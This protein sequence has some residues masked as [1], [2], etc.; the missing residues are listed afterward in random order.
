MRDEGVLG[1]VGVWGHLDRLDGD[2]LQR[3]AAGVE[4]LGYGTL[5]VPETVGREPFVALAA[6]ALSSTRLRVGTS[7]ASIWARD[8][9]SMKM[10][11]RTLQELSG[12]RFRLG[13][14]VS[15]HH[16]AQKVRG[17]TYERPLTRMREYLE[18]Y[19]A[20]PYRGP[21][22]DPDADP[23]MLLAALRVR[24]LELAA[25]ETDGV[26]PYLVT[27]ERVRWMRGVIDAVSP[28]EDQRA[29]LAVTLPVVVTTDADEGRAIAR[30]Y[31]APY[32][33]TPN[34]H[35]SWLAQG[36][37][38]SDWEKPGSDRLVEEM[39][40][41]GDVGTL[42]Q[43]VRE[44]HAAGAD[45]VALIPLGLDGDTENMATLEVLADELRDS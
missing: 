31:L 21:V 20:A 7:I 16:L 14:G 33:R 36:F 24:M 12:G 11:A 5:W 19:R 26:F 8:A 41:T 15:H 29:L 1:S 40:A 2:A 23:P 28:A 9:V 35:A 39:V 25:T 45:H 43:R 10:A 4:E 32:L 34:Y 6:A 22:H 42:V 17:H 13:L 38:E 27:S 30:A 37:S 3:Y 18:A 44:F